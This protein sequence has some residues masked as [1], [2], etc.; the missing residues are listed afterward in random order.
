MSMAKQ[1]PWIRLEGVRFNPNRV[2]ASILILLNS[3]VKAAV[4]VLQ[5]ETISRVQHV[6]SNDN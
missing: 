6:H 4:Q 1:F 5:P 2:Q 3:L